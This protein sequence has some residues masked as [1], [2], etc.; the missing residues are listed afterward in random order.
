M[1]SESF[2]CSQSKNQKLLGLVW[3]EV[4]NLND[5]FGNVKLLEAT[6]QTN[7]LNISLT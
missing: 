4:V 3:I 2:F 7:L 5:E 6:Q 1:T